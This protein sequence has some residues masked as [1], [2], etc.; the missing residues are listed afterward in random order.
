MRPVINEIDIWRTAALMVKR[1]G[2]DAAC[3]AARR[4]DEC[5]ESGDLDG[6]RLWLAII[7]AIEALQR[8]APE[9]GERTH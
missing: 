9:S 7:R 5:L 6:Q 1:H 4:A 3:S 8:K 2:S